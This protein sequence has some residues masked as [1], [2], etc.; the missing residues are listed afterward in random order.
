[1]VGCEGE[2]GASAENG[3]DSSVW[4]KAAEVDR[5]KL[6]KI[7]LEQYNVVGWHCLAQKIFRR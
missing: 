3:T 5:Q 6:C 1:M 2:A 4:Q 7:M